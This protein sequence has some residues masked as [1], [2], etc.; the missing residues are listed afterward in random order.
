M[1]ETPRETTKKRDVGHTSDRHPEKLVRRVLEEEKR[2]LVE[3][4]RLLSEGMIVEFYTEQL[5]LRVRPTIKQLYLKMPPKPKRAAK[6][7]F[8]S[9]VIAYWLGG[10]AS[11]SSHL[12]TAPIVMNLN[13]VEARAEAKAKAEVDLRPLAELLDRL[14]EELTIVRNLARYPS[15]TNARAIVAKTE[16]LLKQLNKE[17]DRIERFLTN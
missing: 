2:V 13:I 3:K 15:A 6:Q 10:K 17:R 4:A 11:L 7:A 1:S 9:T 5:C 8:E 12:D 16:A 14:I